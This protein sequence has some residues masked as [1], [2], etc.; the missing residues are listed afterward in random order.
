MAISHNAV[1]ESDS[2]KTDQ[3]QQ[4]I[5]SL[6]NFDDSVPRRCKSRENTRLEFKESFSFGN[7]PEYAR[8]MAAFSNA[9]GGFIVFGIKDAPRELVGI[10]A[11]RFNDIDG[12]KLSTN[13][14][15]CLEPA[16]DWEV[17][18]IT[19]DRHTLGVI[20]VVECENKPVICIKNSGKKLKE[21]DIYYRYNGQTRRI[22]H[23][24]LRQI[25]TDNQEK[26]HEKWRKVFS[27]V[28]RIGVENVQLLDMEKKEMVG[29]GGRLLI[30][31]ELMKEIRFIRE[32]NF[33]EKQGEGLP[34]LEVIGKVQPI[35]S[36]SISLVKTIQKEVSI[37]EKD[38]LEGFLEQKKVSSPKEYL[39]QAA[40]E[41]SH[42]LPIFYY[43][44]L[45]GFN[46]TGLR[47]YLT[48]HCTSRSKLLERL[49]RP[50][51]LALGSIDAQSDAGTERREIFE[52]LEQRD[53]DD[54]LELNRFRLF[55]AITHYKPTKVPPALLRQLARIVS[56]KFCSLK[57]NERT[58]FRKAIAHLDQLQNGVN[59]L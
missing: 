44:R 47:D 6:L 13:L 57:S 20:A 48:E 28:S 40:R 54:L 16:L 23:Q 22:K 3:L 10:D 35:S 18:T 1:F 42:Y 58:A 32:G 27:E 2:V 33:T 39:R 5:Q 15:S 53:F 49:D 50:A 45:A 31:D 7:L 46:T 21:G 9:R 55:E 51:N 37:N 14:N 41:S 8:T 25:L 34:T 52:K 12:E 56:E 4:T 26:V 43:S 24:E 30:S 11:A 38:I 36:E 59:Y 19:V 29:K 17:F